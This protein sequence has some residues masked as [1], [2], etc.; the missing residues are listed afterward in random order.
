MATNA[1]VRQWLQDTLQLHGR[2]VFSSAVDAAQVFSEIVPPVSKD[3]ATTLALQATLRQL[4]GEPKT[5]L[6]QLRAS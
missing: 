6:P 3:D 5:A 2:V 4:C 1:R